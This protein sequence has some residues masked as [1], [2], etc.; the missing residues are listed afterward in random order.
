[1]ELAG[2]YA[3]KTTGYTPDAFPDQRLM[4]E[5]AKQTN[6]PEIRQAALQ[7]QYPF[8]L[9]ELLNSNYSPLVKETIVNALDFKKPTWPITK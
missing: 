4:Q 2:K 9:S 3:N 1:M 6:D 7:Y 8:K 5:I